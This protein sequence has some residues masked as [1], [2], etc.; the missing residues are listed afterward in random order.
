MGL[1][2]AKSKSKSKFCSECGKP[3]AHSAPAA[4][5]SEVEIQG[6]FM[7]GEEPAKDDWDG[8]RRKLL[9]HREE[10]EQGT[11]DEPV[12]PAAIITIEMDPGWEKL[13]A[14]QPSISTKFRNGGSLDDNRNTCGNPAPVVDEVTGTIAFNLRVAAGYGHA[15]CVEEL[16]KHRACV[17]TMTCHGTGWWGSGM[18]NALHEACIWGGGEQVVALL[19]RYRADANIT[20]WR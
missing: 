5:T 8:L 20:G 14:T 1:R 11:K 10:I 4:D 12:D 2:P 16:L 3:L 15:N 17:N 18:R 9:A 6:F 13:W 7:P 19:L